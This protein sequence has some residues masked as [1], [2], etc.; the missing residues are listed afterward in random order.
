MDTL[1]KNVNASEI[2]NNRGGNEAENSKMKSQMSGVSNAEQ[3][4]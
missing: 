4:L 1:A 3:E 2:S